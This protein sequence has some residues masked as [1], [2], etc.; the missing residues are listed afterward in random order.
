MV[1][2]VVGGTGSATGNDTLENVS[3]VLGDVAVIGAELVIAAGA[4]T[5]EPA[6]VGVGLV[7]LGGAFL[8]KH[9]ADWISEQ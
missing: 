8:A 3:T 2:Y 9:V 1:G 7:T 6:L 4:V 5:A